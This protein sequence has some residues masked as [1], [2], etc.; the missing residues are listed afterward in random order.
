MCP[1]TWWISKRPVCLECSQ[2]G[3][4]F[5]SHYIAGVRVF[6]HAL[7]RKHYNCIIQYAISLAIF[8]MLQLCYYEK[9]VFKNH[10]VRLW[11]CQFV[12]IIMPIFFTHLESVSLDAY[13]LVIFHYFSMFNKLF[14]LFLIIKIKRCSG[15]LWS[16]LVGTFLLY[17]SLAFSS[18]CFMF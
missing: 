11:I 15:F 17:G 10:T 3:G 1:C 8:Y 12:L 7:H 4:E 6:V 9:Y 5:K 14:V 13:K 2:Q 16:I 18:P